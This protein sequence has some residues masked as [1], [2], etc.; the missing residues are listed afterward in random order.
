MKNVL[1]IILTAV[2]TIFSLELE[3]HPGV[4]IVMDSQ[5]NVFYTDLVHVWKI[6]PEGDLSIAVKD[7]HTHQ[8][9]LDE[10][11]NLYGEHVWYNGEERDTW[12]YY[13][14]CLNSFGEIEYPVPE[15]EGFPENNTLVRDR[16]DNSFFSKKSEVGEF[17]MKQNSE[18]QIDRFGIHTFNNIRWIYSNNKASELLVIDHLNLKRV[19]ENGDVTIISGELHDSG[20]NHDDIKDMH[21]LMGVWT[22]KM[23]Q[24]Y[25]A[26]FG[27][28]KVKKIDAN[29]KV[30]TIYK[31]SMGWSP[32]GG[33]IAPNGTLWVMEFSVFNK[34][35]V[36]KVNPNGK[37]EIFKE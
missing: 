2:T 26:A 34:T 37:D 29:G 21:Y 9:F 36:R 20:K 18:G 28:K 13:V 30:E 5:G 16:N 33:L 6:S 31:S 22:D 24:I 15:T 12:S 1:I 7:V 25:V 8:L 23:D 35:R 14:W 3:A 19:D 10:N 27:A 4:G 32:C 17:L 11:D